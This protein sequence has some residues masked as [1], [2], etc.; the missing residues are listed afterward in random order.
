[1]WKGGARERKREEEEIFETNFLPPGDHCYL[2]EQEQ[3]RCSGRRRFES[4][5]PGLS[6]KL[7]LEGREMKWIT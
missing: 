1:M 3:H 6:D 7:L 4:M 2:E 5:D